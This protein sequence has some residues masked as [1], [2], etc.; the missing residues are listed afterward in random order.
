[1]STPIPMSRAIRDTLDALL[2]DSPDVLLMG[3]AV[4]S[5][6][7]VAGTC[8]GLLAAHGPERVIETPLSES[9]LLG[10]AA[11]L[12][13]GGKIPVLEL[14]SAGRVQGALEQL[15]GEISTLARRTGGEFLA[16]LVLRLPCGP[17]GTLQEAGVAGLLTS[18]EGL[19]VASPSTAGDAAGLL[20]GAVAHRGPVVLLEP[21]TLYNHRGPVSGLPV[22][23]G[24]AHTVR[25]GHHV[26]LLAWGAGVATALAAA[27]AAAADGFE[28]EVLDLRSLA[29]LD[30]GCI[31]E[32]VRRTGR[33]LVVESGGP[34]R[35]LADRLLRAATEAAFL[36]LESP[37]A[38]VT[39]GKDQ[40]AHAL[41]SSVTF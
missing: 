19:A 28:A 33:V 34:D 1:M 24:T 8:D 36:Y 31:A 30:L 4:G 22:P 15:L 13:M 16:P 21:L 2:I 38:L 3:E 35:A 18:A 14:P 27:E 20:R 9:G 37:P 25:P 10:V 40:V 12:A 39:G 6:G 26:T 5:Q 23:L 41:V 17:A 29:P 7:G 32:S 11:G